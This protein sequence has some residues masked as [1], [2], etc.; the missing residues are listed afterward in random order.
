[1]AREVEPRPFLICREFQFYLPL[2]EFPL[3]SEDLRSAKD[4]GLQALLS[5][6]S[7]RLALRVIGWCD[8]GACEV[9]PEQALEA[10][11]ILIHIR[12]R[13][14]YGLFTLCD[15]SASLRDVNCGNSSGAE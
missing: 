12:L 8:I 13:S 4:R 11:F 6:Q 15:S 14:D 2:F 1:L 9:K 5:V 3:E 10:I 7:W